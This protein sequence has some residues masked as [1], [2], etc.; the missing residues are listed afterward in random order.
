[1]AGM[2]SLAALAA[3]GMGMVASGARAQHVPTAADPAAPEVSQQATKTVPAVLGQKK[4][5]V[6][7]YQPL[8]DDGITLALNYTGDA[9]ANATGGFARKAAYTGQIYVGADFD[10]E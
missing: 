2:K 10:L 4:K 7:T 8:A 5:G 1:M 9:A 3:L 6:E